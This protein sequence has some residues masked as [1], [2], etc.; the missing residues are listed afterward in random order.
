MTDTATNRLKVIE[1]HYG[2]LPFLSW[3]PKPTA[4]LYLR[5]LGRG[6]RYYENLYT[7]W[8]LRRLCDGF[9]IIDYTREIVRNPERYA[10]LDVV[11][12]GGITKKAALALLEHAYWLSPGYVWLLKKSP[13]A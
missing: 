3:L 11:S 4:N 6:N 12:G 2:R 1:T 10:A 7:Y 5:A 9:E 8:T 13:A